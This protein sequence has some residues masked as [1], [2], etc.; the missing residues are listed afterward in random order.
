MLEINAFAKINGWL[1]ITGRRADGFHELDTAF[2]PVGLRDS[3]FLEPRDVPGIGFT[4]EGGEEDVPVDGS[5]LAVRAAEAFMEASGCGGGARIHL[6]KRIPSGAGL[7]GGSSDAAAVLL[8]LNQLHGGLLTEE[9]LRAIAA[10]IGSDVPFFLVGK[11][12]VGTGRGEVLRELNPPPFMRLLLVKP[13]FGVPTAWAYGAYKK[14]NPEIPARPE[15]PRWFEND[16]EEPVFRKYPMLRILKQH[17]E[18]SPGVLGAAM[19]GSGSTIF[20]ALDDS[21]DAARLGQ[22]LQNDFGDTLRFWETS[23]PPGE[24]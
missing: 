3:V 20:A 18:D 17:L 9:A 16:L 13:P 23:T 11:A 7:G 19:S 1:R 24:N 10:R 5:N 4:C 21:T 22:M 2:L 15:P 12:A 14:L 8:G 6:V